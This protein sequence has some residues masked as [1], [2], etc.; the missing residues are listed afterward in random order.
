LRCAAGMFRRNVIVGVAIART[1]FLFS[2]I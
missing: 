1:L 2:H